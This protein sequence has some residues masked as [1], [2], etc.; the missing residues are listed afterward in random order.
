M[1]GMCRFSR[2]PR[3]LGRKHPRFLSDT[4]VVLSFGIPV[5]LS[6]VAKLTEVSVESSHRRVF[7]ASR[8]SDEAV[9]KMER[10]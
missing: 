3:D 5:Q 2:A 1:G 10:V 4:E 9:H 7:S 6:N 8:G